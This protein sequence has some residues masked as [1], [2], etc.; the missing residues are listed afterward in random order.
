MKFISLGIAL[1]YRLRFE[2]TLYI[3]SEIDFRLKSLA[4]PNSK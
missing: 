2:S 4:V 3:K 1:T